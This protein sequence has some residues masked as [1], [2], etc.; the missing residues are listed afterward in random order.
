MPSIG[1]FLFSSF[2]GRMPIPMNQYDSYRR[3]GLNG[4]G[5]SFDSQT[6]DPTTITTRAIIDTAK[7]DATIAAYRAIVQKTVT[8]KDGTEKEFK[9]VLVARVGRFTWDLL[10]S[11]A[12]SYMLTA[13]WDLV[14]DAS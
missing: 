10:I 6:V 3:S 8:V 11:P 12:A 14:V 7:L 13:E 2:A 1:T 9:G 4:L 5:I